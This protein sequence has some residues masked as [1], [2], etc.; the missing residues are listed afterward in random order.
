MFGFDRFNLSRFSLGSQDN[1]LPINA[2][3]TEELNQVAGVAIPVETTAFFN[4]VLRGSSRG[5][6]AL[7][8]AF[9]SEGVF[10]AVCEM[11]ANI[12]STFL[13]AGALSHKVFG[14]QNSNIIANLSDTLAARSYSSKNIIWRASYNDT[15]T[16]LVNGV[17]DIQTSLLS[18]EVLT[19]MLEA[20]STQTEQATFTITL[21]PG[22]EIRIDSDTFRVMKDGENILYA[23]SGDWITLSR[24]LLYLDIESA[25]G[26]SLQGNLIYVER[27]L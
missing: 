12:C 2:L 20:S 9:A 7:Q 11:Q 13:G 26:G 14:S 24:E 19:A 3:L 6:I 15:L 8:S 5:A 25:S 4:D 18:Y 27:Y 21:P 23:Q 10:H 22:S 17:K 16:A 1:S